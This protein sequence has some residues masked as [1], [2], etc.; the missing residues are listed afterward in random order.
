MDLNTLNIASSTQISVDSAY[1]TATSAA[2]TVTNTS[3]IDSAKNC[4]FS[5]PENSIVAVKTPSISTLPKIELNK[6]T[7]NNKG[8]K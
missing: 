5:T 6:N 3:P 4:L 1:A 2:S 7:L 8:K